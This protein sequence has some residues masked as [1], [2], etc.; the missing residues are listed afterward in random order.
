VGFR[1]PRPRRR[2][3]ISTL[4]PRPIRWEAIFRSTEVEKDEVEKGKVKDSVEEKDG[5]GG[6]FTSDLMRLID[7]VARDPGFLD[8]RVGDLGGK[9]KEELAKN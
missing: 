1:R 3:R 9:Q 7:G 2:P 6:K 4:P 8:R 5:E